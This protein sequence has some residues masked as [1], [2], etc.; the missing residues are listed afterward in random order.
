MNNY[1]TELSDEYY[2]CG[3][4]ETEYLYNSYD[5][6]LVHLC[7]F[8]HTED[9]ENDELMFNIELEE[10][11][12]DYKLKD[13]L[14]EELKNKFNYEPSWQTHLN[15]LNVQKEIKSFDKSKLKN[16]YRSHWIKWFKSFIY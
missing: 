3:S 2:S 14:I 12:R 4:D 6:R 13:K 9:T 10:I 11:P 7:E 15:Y 1:Y 5:D 8:E 16:P